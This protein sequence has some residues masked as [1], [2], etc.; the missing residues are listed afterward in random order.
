[1][2]ALRCQDEKERQH[3]LWAAK[4]ALHGLRI[5]ICEADRSSR[6]RPRL[7]P[8]LAPLQGLHRREE[9]QQGDVLAQD[10]MDMGDMAH[11]ALCRRGL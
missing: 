11:R 8:R 9:G 7:L 5:V 6:K 4:V 10:L 1:M 2:R 3:I